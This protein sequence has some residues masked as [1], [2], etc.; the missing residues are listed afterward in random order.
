MLYVFAGDNNYAIDQKIKSVIADELKS[1]PGSDIHNID[2]LTTKLH[3][4]Y[5]LM[6]GYSLFSSHKIIV[7]KNPIKINGFSEGYEK[8][9]GQASD[10]ALIIAGHEMD[11]RT[12]MYKFFKKQQNFM[13]FN[14]LSPAELNKW[15]VEY[16]KSIGAII[17][18]FDATFLIGRLGNDQYLLKNEIDKLALLGNNINKSN[19]Q[20]FSDQTIE[21]SIFDLIEATFSGNPKKAL[22]IYDEQIQLKVEPIQIMYLLTWQLI[23]LSYMYLGKNLS[24]QELEKKYKVKSFFQSKARRVVDRMSYPE[25]R[26]LV[27]RIADI[28]YKSK[29]SS[30][31]LDEALRNFIVTIS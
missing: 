21:S 13:E 19:I 10:N 4:I 16:S 29:T 24:S 23:S 15:V 27:S 1:N 28:D 7:I 17:S 3:E 18:S 5:S 31:E 26:G 14:S 30:L 12:S 20:N 6:D 11:K 2:E 25:F 22:E 8:L 9:M